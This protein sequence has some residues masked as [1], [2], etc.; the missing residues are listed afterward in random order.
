MTGA[1]ARGVTPLP[2]PLRRPRSGG[3]PAAPGSVGFTLLELLIVLAIVAL[4]A[5]LVAPRIGSGGAVLFKAQLREA[6]GALNY[7][8]R[9]AIVN[10]RPVEA[11]FQ[12]VAK[13]A[14]GG[15]NRWVSRGATVSVAEGPPLAEGESAFTV[16]FFPEGGSSGGRFTLRHEG[17]EAEIRVDAVTGRVTAG[18]LGEE[19]T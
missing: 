7:A 16:V 1:P 13:G 10:G 3:R 4:A 19:S 5:A 17:Y 11:N 14:A 12:N 6:V 2:P 15:P 8:R 9:S 18:I